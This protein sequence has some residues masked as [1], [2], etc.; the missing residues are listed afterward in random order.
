MSCLSLFIFATT[1]KT[2][3]EPHF[4]SYLNT[5]VYK[6]L[7]LFFS[8]NI[9]ITC[10]VLFIVTCILI[11]PKLVSEIADF[12]CHRLNFINLLTSANLN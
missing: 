4:E 11:L 2:L 9:D 3:A 8:S 5:P 10:S 7:L 6:I 1:C 12:D